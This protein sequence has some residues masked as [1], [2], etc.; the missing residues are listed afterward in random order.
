MGSFVLAAQLYTLRELLKG[1]D[2]VTTREVLSQVKAMGYKAIQVSGI[3]DITPEIA[4]MYL[5][6]SKEL[7]LDICATHFNL[8]YIEENLDW[9]IKLHLLWE[10]K[11]V[12]IGSMPEAL[13]TPEGIDIFADHCDVIAKKLKTYGLTL[14][15]HNHKFEFEKRDGRPWLE[16]LLEKF[17]R[18]CVQLELDTYW[19]Q[20]GGANPVEWIEKVPGNMGVIHFKDMRIVGDEQ[21]FAE[22]GQGNINWQAIIEATKKAG[23]V[24]AAVEQDGYTTKPLE[25]LKVSIDYL[26]TFL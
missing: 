17:N 20:A 24:Y 22:I 18:S 1:K 4:D 15:Y 6:I 19:V 16:I 21:Q 12:G 25:S 3:G 26:K 14:V 7:D 13:R 11:Y 2:E 8:A 10:C 9:I 23:V 5:K